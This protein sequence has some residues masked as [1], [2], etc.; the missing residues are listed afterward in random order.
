MDFIYFLL[1]WSIIGVIAGAYIIYET[2]RLSH[3]SDQTVA[4]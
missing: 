4:V 1:F 2:N 3:E